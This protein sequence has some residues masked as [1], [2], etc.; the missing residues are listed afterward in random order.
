[1]EDLDPLTAVQTDEV[2]HVLDGPEYRNLHL[3]E[4]CQDPSGIDRERDVSRMSGLFG[5][6]IIIINT[7]IDKINSLW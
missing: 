2:R 4:G 5:I 7:R 6:L 3:P 1:M